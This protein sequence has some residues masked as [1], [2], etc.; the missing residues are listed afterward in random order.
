M[1]GA[2]SI[3]RMAPCTISKGEPWGT[4]ETPVPPH[5]LPA[6][7]DLQLM[8]FLLVTVVVVPEVFLCVGIGFMGIY[9]AVMPLLDG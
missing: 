1:P 8:L 7:S 2:P 9:A 5:R 4:L 6:L 3:V